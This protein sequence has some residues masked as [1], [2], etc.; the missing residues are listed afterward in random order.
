VTTIGVLLTL[1]E[2]CFCDVE[3][4]L[5]IWS[6]SQSMQQYK[7]QERINTKKNHGQSIVLTEWIKA[8]DI[9]VYSVKLWFTWQAQCDLNRTMNKTTGLKPPSTSVTDNLPAWNIY[10]KVSLTMIQCLCRRTEASHLEGKERKFY[11]YRKRSEFWTVSNVRLYVSMRPTTA[12]SPSF[13]GY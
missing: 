2:P 10:N 6:R 7:N 9:T 13:G 12:H 1:S 4:L 3:D 11:V 8:W 5:N